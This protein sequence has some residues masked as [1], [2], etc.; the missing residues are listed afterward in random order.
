MLVVSV[1]LHNARTGRVWRL[2]QAIIANDGCG[3]HTRGHYLVRIGRR[4]QTLQEVW[5]HPH[6]AGR[7]EHYPRLRLSVWHLVRRALDACARSDSSPSRHA[8]PRPSRSE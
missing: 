7:V 1:D 4:G 8:A 6:R 3:S 5:T 2:G